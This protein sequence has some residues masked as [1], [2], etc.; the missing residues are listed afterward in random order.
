MASY[1]FPVL[2]LVSFFILLLLVSPSNVIFQ[3]V[4]TMS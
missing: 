2:F 1:K 4:E 3:G